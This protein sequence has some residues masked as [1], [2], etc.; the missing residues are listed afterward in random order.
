MVFSVAAKNKHSILN[1]KNQITR[2]R[3]AGSPMRA[4]TLDRYVARH[5]D[6]E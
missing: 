6:F 4:P 2:A 1:K 5:F 3:R